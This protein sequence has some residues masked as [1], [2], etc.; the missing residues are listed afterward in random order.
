VSVLCQITGLNRAGFYRWRVPRLATPV[1]IELRDQM[2]KVAVEWPAYG[3]RRIT[4]ELQSLRK[5]LLDELALS[6]A[7][8]R[9]LCPCDPGI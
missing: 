5:A 8:E 4:M 9:G 7:P 1:E 2:Q 3:D 6:P